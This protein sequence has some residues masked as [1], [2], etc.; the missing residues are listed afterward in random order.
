[1]R[2]LIIVLALSFFGCD[3]EEN[4]K[5]IE[6]PILT[7]NISG[8][9]IAQDEFK[10]TGQ[11]S[12][13]LE[14][15]DP[16]KIG[17]QAVSLQR[18][19]GLKIAKTNSNSDGSYSLDIPQGGLLIDTSFSLAEV[20]DSDT[21]PVP[22]T[23]D[24]TYSLSVEVPDDGQGKAI[25]IRKKIE[26]SKDTIANGSYEVGDTPL[27]EVTAVTGFIKFESDTIQVNRTDVFIPG[28]QFFIRTGDDGVFAMLFVP[29]G[30]HII[31]I[32]N[33]LSLK[34]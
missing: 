13:D 25:G 4:T 29:P 12:L 30:D 2:A 3:D 27:K 1:M 8:P 14:G 32:Q 31:R 19:D 33:P 11:L 23:T 24:F 17:D 10:I 34:M 6:Q 7:S 28:Q 5:I 22:T 15:S 20:G 26:L 18:S 21:K 16:S 9:E